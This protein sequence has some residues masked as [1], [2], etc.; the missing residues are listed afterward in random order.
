MY[1]KPHSLKVKHYTALLID[2]ND[3]LDSCTE[4]TM[5]DKI[6]V[7]ELNKML[8]N[9]MPNSSSNQDYVQVFDCESIYFLK[10]V[11]MFEPM[12][13][14]K[15]IVEG[16]VTPY[17]LKTTRAESNR[18]ALIRKNK[19]EDVS[20]NMHPATDGSA[21]KRHK[22]CVDCSKNKSKTCIFHGVVNSSNEFKALGRFETKYD[23]DQPT[24]DRGSN[25]V[26]SKI[27]QEKQKTRY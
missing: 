5:S 12:E 3:Y 23:A 14:A 8:F 15:S 27:L 25:P 19:G 21:G 26:S 20:S 4:A 22:R 2:L 7:T 24:M 18:N 1:E 10:A 13:I 16:V 6:G 11:N 9:S 17:Y